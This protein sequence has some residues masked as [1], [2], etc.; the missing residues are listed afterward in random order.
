[1]LSRAG[2]N[3]H[4]GEAGPGP[5]G[6]AVRKDHSDRPINLLLRFVLW[7][8]GPEA[9][10]EAPLPVRVFYKFDSGRWRSRSTRQLRGVYRCR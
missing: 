3:R 5:A 4:D 8:L 9:R 2:C 6:S 7:L 10:F 1:M